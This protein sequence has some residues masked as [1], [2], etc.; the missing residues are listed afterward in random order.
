MDRCRRSKQL[1]FKNLSK[2][3]MKKFIWVALLAI[4]G[5]G[6][7]AYYLFNKPVT[8]MSDQKSEIALESA[9][10]F[11]AFKADENAANARYLGKIVAVSGTIREVRVVDG[12]TK[13]TLAAGDESENVLFE[14]EPLAGQ[15][16]PNY[17]VGQPCTLKGEC[18]GADLDGTVF[19]ARS[20]VVQ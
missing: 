3:I 14:L 9:Q 10:L 12:I 19:M 11:A 16:Q 2:F 1:I 18:A 7:Y 17:Q 4:V 8:S 5:G 6:A 15:N 20:V 13:I